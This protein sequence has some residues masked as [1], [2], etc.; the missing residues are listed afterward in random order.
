MQIKYLCLCTKN[1][2]KREMNVEKYRSEL[3][4]L[5][6]RKSGMFGL[7]ENFINCFNLENNYDGLVFL[8]DDVQLCKKFKEKIE[9]EI[10]ERSKSTISFFENAMSKN[11]LFS[12]WRNGARFNWMQCNYFPKE[13]CD[14]LYNENIEE[15]KEWYFQ[16]YKKWTYPSDTF[17]AYTLGKNNLNYYMKVPFLVQHLDFKSKLGA[18]PT[19]RQSKYFIDEVEK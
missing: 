10:A 11:E 1:D 6:V 3:P 14:L 18:R 5:E 9:F 19:N 13:V 2:I 4:K 15:F 16:K 8:E 17:V 7:F 12:E